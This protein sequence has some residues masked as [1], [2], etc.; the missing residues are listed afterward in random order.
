MTT[1]EIEKKI[2]NLNK[3]LSGMDGGLYPGKVLEWMIE[4]RARLKKLLESPLYHALN[5]EDND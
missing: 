4:E 1:K 5:R 3:K 2:E